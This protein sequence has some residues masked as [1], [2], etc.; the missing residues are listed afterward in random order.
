MTDLRSSSVSSI[1]EDASF[2]NQIDSFINEEKGMKS[3][4]IFQ[5][6]GENKNNGIENGCLLK[7][8]KEKVVGV[9]KEDYN[10]DNDFF[11]REFNLIEVKSKGVDENDRLFKGGVIQIQKIKCEEEQLWVGKFNHSSK[12]FATGGKTGVLTVWKFLSIKDSLDIYTTQNVNHLSKTPKLFSIFSKIPRI[13]YTALI[14]WTLSIWIGA[15][16]IVILLSAS[17]W[18][19]EQFCVM[20]NKMRR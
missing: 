2:T 16:K 7:D 1:Y 14:N 17:L 19:V 12:Y 18:I 13:K 6:E 5:K 3:Y 15:V 9:I 8:F 4:L 11:L 20:L 10:D